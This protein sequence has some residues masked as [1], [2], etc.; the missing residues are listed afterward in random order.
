MA[1]VVRDL[2]RYGS[3]RRRRRR[4][5]GISG[6]RRLRPD[7]GLVRVLC[8]IKSHMARDVYT[9]RDGFYRH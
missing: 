6:R 3:N 8:F 4:G 9:T 7:Q 2:D 1:D 5:G